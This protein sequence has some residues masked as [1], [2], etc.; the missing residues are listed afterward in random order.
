MIPKN[1]EPLANEVIK[2][3][4]LEPPGLS[5]NEILE[6]L[7]LVGVLNF[8]FWSDKPTLFTVRHLG[9]DWMGY[10]SMCAV[11][12]RAKAKGTPVCKPEFYEVMTREQMEE[13]FKSDSHLQIPLLEKRRINLHKAAAVPKQIQW[14]MQCVCECVVVDL[15]GFRG[16]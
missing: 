14:E 5:N 9:R 11:L 7:F 4:P 8:C 1:G 12:A 6:W 13:I 10:H 15:G 2:V 16:F 3:D